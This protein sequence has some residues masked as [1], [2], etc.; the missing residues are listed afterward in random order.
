MHVDWMVQ[1]LSTAFHLNTRWNQP[2]EWDI[3]ST[4][5]VN[6][7]ICRIGSIVWYLVHAVCLDILTI[8]SLFLLHDGLTSWIC[9]SR[10][11]S[12]WW[13]GEFVG[14]FLTL[15]QVGDFINVVMVTNIAVSKIDAWSSFNRTEAANLLY[16]MIQSTSILVF[17]WKFVQK[18]LNT[19]LFFF[20][21]AILQLNVFLCKVH[22]TYDVIC[23]IIR[24]RITGLAANCWI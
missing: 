21:H 10:T 1:K 4:A 19:V 16:Q 23:V 8:K 7:A 22:N 6:V 13:S 14:V 9:R 24:E 17:I 3:F 5:H 18:Q 20:L 2:T 11:Q 12:V 15:H